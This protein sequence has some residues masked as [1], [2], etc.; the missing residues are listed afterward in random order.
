MKEKISKNQ[1]V[2]ICFKSSGKPISKNAFITVLTKRTKNGTKIHKALLFALKDFTPYQGDFIFNHLCRIESPN[3]PPNDIVFLTLV[4]FVGCSFAGRF[5]KIAWS[6]AFS[7]KSV[8]FAFSLQKFG[9]RLFRHK[10]AIVTPALV[11]EMLRVLTKAMGIVGNLFEPIAL[12]QVKTGNVTLVNSF[13]ELDNMYF[14]FHEEAKKN[15]NLLSRKSKK[16]IEDMGKFFSLKFH[17]MSAGSYNAYAMIDAFFSRLEHLLILLFPFMNYDRIKYDLV[18]LMNSIWS[19]KFKTI[20]DLKTDKVAKDLYDRMISLR[21]RYRNPVSHGNFQKDGKSFFSHFPTGAISCHLS[22][23]NEDRSQSILKLDK[24]AFD[25]ICKLFDEVDEYIATG[26]SKYGFQYAR[27]GLNV[28]Y[29]EK[30]LSKYKSA[31]I[32]DE[33]F[34]EFVE[35]ESKVADMNA[36]M[37]W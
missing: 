27:S 24:T 37:D 35:L 16:V 20:F 6:V 19:E 21:A 33:C 34:K 9:L 8:P 28:S 15:F 1:I 17:R 22:C 18:I 30:T 31:S 14:Y 4:N 10:T 12:A 13:V 29:D 5:E 25:K 3:L 23:I 7:F 26:P 32:D 36:N 11:E 2:D